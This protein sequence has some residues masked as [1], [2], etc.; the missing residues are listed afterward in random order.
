MTYC[1][2]RRGARGIGPCGQV[3]ARARARWTGPGQRGARHRLRSHP[4]GPD[5]RPRPRCPHQ[6]TGPAAPARLPPLSAVPLR[7]SW[8]QPPARGLRPRAGPDRRHRQGPGHR[9]RRRRGRGHRR[10]R[11]QRRHRRGDCHHRAGGLAGLGRRRRAS[12]AIAGTG[13]VVTLLAAAVVTAGGA[14][15]LQH[16]APP[17]PQRA[18][19]H[20]VAR[21][22]LAPRGPRP[23][24]R[25]PP[26]VGVE[27]ERQPGIVVAGHHRCDATATGTRPPTR[28]PP[29]LV[30]AR[31][32]SR[33]RD[34]ASEPPARTSLTQ[35]LDPDQLSTLYGPGTPPSLV[36]PCAPAARP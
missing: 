22:P 3:A 8:R 18:H 17:A 7:G 34:R 12:G 25:T 21:T 29:A 19:H 26:A 10:D 35:T 23:A 11:R 2:R 32:P 9:G 5:R 28:W 6:R 14:I 16:I 13:H 1:G 36:D 30:H 15:E 20:H 24:R 4:R 31:R 27:P 33:A